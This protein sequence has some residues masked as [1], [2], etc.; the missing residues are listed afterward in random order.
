MAV[1]FKQSSGLFSKL[2]TISSLP[3]VFTQTQQCILVIVH[4]LLLLA[5]K[6]SIEMLLVMPIFAGSWAS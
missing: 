5:N 2:M 6:Q 3:K 4:T 1:N